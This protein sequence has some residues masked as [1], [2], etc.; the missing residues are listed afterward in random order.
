MPVLVTGIQSTRVY[1]ARG[2]F[3]AQDF[4]GLD[5]CDNHRDEEE[6]EA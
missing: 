3:S 4:G 6:R 2:L 1:A 5:P